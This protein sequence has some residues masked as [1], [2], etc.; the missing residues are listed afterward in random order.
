MCRCTSVGDST[1]LP[2]LAV[3]SGPLH[4]LVKTHPTLSTT[5]SSY[6]VFLRRA[7]SLL[8]CPRL[9]SPRLST[10]VLCVLCFVMP[11]GRGGLPHAF[12]PISPYFFIAGT[13]H[14]P[15][16]SS[17]PPLCRTRPRH[18]AAKQANAFKAGPSFDPFSIFHPTKDK[19][20]NTYT[21]NPHS[22]LHLSPLITTAKA[23]DRRRRLRRP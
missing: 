7:T 2:W 5:P 18:H 15:S 23:T 11:A 19:Q 4:S 14:N 16:P 6:I 13:P 10:D 21:T 12:V 9:P 1:T 8:L 17:L 20:D 3:E 22:P